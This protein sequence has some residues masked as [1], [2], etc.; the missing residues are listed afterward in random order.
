[1]ESASKRIAAKQRVSAF[2][3]LKAAALSSK[4]LAELASQIAENPFA[5]VIEMIKTLLARL[6]EEAAAEADH[7]AW[8][9]EQ[10]K[11]NKLKREKKTAEVEKLQAEIAM[12]AN[13]IETMGERIKTLIDEQ[14]ALT[15]AMAE[16]TEFRTKE[17]A[18]NEDTIADAKAGQESGSRLSSTSRRR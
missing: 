10:L 8:C 13:Q 14:A 15:K 1:M 6:K 16:V 9:D 3:K 17:K 12:L 11:N 18:E 7:K 5:K 2:L 4:A